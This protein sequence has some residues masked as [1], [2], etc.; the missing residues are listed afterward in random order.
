[1]PNKTLQTFRRVAL[2]EGVSFL[3]LLLVAMPLKY[4]GGIAWP[5][6]VVGWAHGVLFVAFLALAFEAKSILNKNFGWLL[7]SF[8]ASLVP[9]GT[10]W[11]DRQLEKEGAWSRVA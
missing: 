8:I 2:A 3:I 10:F 1:M 6:K 5:V 7:I 11:L 9:F 4:A